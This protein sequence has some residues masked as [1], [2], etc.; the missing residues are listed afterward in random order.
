MRTQDTPHRL[1]VAAAAFTLVELL[2]VI[3]IIAML[4][5]LLVPAVSRGIRSAI[6]AQC[7]NNLK[8]NGQ[9]IEMYVNDHDNGYPTYPASNG[10]W[11]SVIARVNADSN[12]LAY[13][14]KPYLGTKTARGIYEPTFLCPGTSKL[15]AKRKDNVQY[16]SNHSARL[17]GPK[18]AA[19]D[20]WGYP[21]PASKRSPMKRGEAPSTEWMLMDVDQMHFS[22][23]PGWGNY[24]DFAPYPG[25]IRRWNALYFDLHVGFVFL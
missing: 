22:I 17:Y 4:A 20:V 23:N 2:V 12:Q 14:L 24:G 1:K 7:I 21:D 3:A 10:V 16:L 6:A 5:A 19:E 8:Q 25:H 9:A 13:H 11:A 18:A 15:P